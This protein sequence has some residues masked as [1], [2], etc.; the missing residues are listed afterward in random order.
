MLAG[1]SAG[2]FKSLEEAGRRFVTMEER[3][4][5]PDKERAAVYESA[6]GKYR[7]LVPPDKGPAV[8][9][10]YRLF[11]GGLIVIHNTISPPHQIIRR[12]NVS[13]PVLGA[14]LISCRKL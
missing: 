5:K 9:C 10:E 12:R 4:Y 14:E 2:I 6:F 8:T 7:E 13:E 11:Y 1:V 3:T